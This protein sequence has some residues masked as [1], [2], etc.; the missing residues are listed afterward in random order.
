[1]CGTSSEMTPN[2]GSQAV[3]FCSQASSTRNSATQRDPSRPFL[4]SWNGYRP[5]AIQD[6]SPVFEKATFTAEHWIELT[7]EGGLYGVTSEYH[8]CIQIITGEL[9]LISVFVHTVT[10]DGL[11]RISEQE[12]GSFQ[13]WFFKNSPC[14]SP[15]LRKSLFC[16]EH[17]RLVASFWPR[18]G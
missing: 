9:V 12:V 1:M 7:M 18:K 14:F 15:K 5:E 10:R 16:R 2:I 4:L 13:I 3:A 8:S 17:T 6:T 11:G